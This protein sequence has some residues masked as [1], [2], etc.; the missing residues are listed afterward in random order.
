M[1]CMIEAIEQPEKASDF[2]IT[3]LSEFIAV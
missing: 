3:L 1:G 2:D